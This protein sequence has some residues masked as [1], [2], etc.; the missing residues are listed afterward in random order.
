VTYTAT[1]T[2]RTTDN[3]QKQTDWRLVKLL[4]P[5]AMRRKRLLAI[6]MTLLVPLALAEA[7]QPILI[8]QAVALIRSEDTLWFLDGRS[9]STGLNILVLLL[10]IT[11]AVKLSLDGVQGYQVQKVGQKITA[12]IRNDLFD[13]VTS[14]SLSFF[15]RTPVGRLITRLTSDVEALGDVFST[16]AIGI[17]GDFFTMVVIAVT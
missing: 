13:H 14:L 12:D 7:A 11:I 17:V 5:Y 1:S 8:G 16:G 3:R 15:D 2:S 4:V 9:L 10:F 6:A